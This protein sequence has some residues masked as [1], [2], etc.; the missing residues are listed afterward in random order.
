MTFITSW[1]TAILLNV[2]PTGHNG[3]SHRQFGNRGP[4]QYPRRLTMTRS[5]TTTRFGAHVALLWNTIG[6]SVVPEHRPIF[7][8]IEILETQNCFNTILDKLKVGNEMPV[9][10]DYLWII[11]ENAYVT[12]NDLTY[13][14][15]T[16]LELQMHS[17]A[18]LEGVAYNTF[19]CLH[20][21][22]F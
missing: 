17:N 19:W 18:H 15:V 1:L 2:I 11:K 12:C 8:V 5:P 10:F 4:F 6:A 3:H 16:L 9:R 14:M 20:L 21:I 22:L 7:L 13:Y